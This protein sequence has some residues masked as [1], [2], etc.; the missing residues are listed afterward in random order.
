MRLEN[1]NSVLKFSGTSSSFFRRSGTG[2]PP[3]VPLTHSLSRIFQNACIA[4]FHQVRRS[5]LSCPSG[6]KGGP[7]GAIFLTLHDI[8]VPRHLLICLTAPMAP[9][10]DVL[11]PSLEQARGA[12]VLAFTI[13]GT[14]A[15]KDVTQVPFIFSMLCATVR[16]IVSLSSVTFVAAQQL[17]SRVLLFAGGVDEQSP[18]PCCQS[19]GCGPLLP[20]TQV[21]PGCSKLAPWLR[22]QDASRIL[23]HS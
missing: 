12:A 5:N 6:I 7:R 3:A 8:F 9:T 2:P 13:V 17:I 21:L 16:T 18:R 20:H 15:V 1:Q 14:A 19:R 22:H 11:V 4:N 23:C 10:V